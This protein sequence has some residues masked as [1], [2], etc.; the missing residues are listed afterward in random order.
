MARPRPGAVAGLAAVVSLGIFAAGCADVEHDPPSSPATAAGAA[1]A[2]AKDPALTAAVTRYH[3]YVVAEVAAL[4]TTTRSFTDAV[5]A[6][7]IAQ[8][9]A[10][11]VPARMHYEDIESVVESL[12]DFD[13]D[14]D[15]RADDVSDPA[16]WIGFHRIEKALW[17][18]GSLAGMAPF[19]NEL[20]LDIFALKARVAGVTFEPVDVATRAG[21]LLADISTTKITGEEDRYSHTDLW[22]I[23]ANI[24]GARE[25][26]ELLKPALVA[27]DPGLVGQL[28]VRFADVTT[29]LDRYRQGSGY[30]DWSSAPELELRALSDAVD[31]LAEPLS[32]VGAALVSKTTG[33]AG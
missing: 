4:Q 8:A 29:R 13:D 22:D 21:D 28:E 26:F 24:A 19:A 18:D 1:Q 15:A 31:A 12:G 14:I 17:A 9:K 11:Y 7:D 10:L 33:S 30:V 20:D 25:A 5:R 32:Q 23:A 6:G 27:R 2:A 3:D 16:K